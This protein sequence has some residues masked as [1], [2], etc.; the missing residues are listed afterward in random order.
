MLRP[1]LFASCS[2]TNPRTICSSGPRDNRDRGNASSTHS[3]AG[4]WQVEATVVLEGEFELEFV[5]ESEIVRVGRALAIV[6][7]TETFG[8]LSLRE[9]VAVMVDRLQAENL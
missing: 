4:E 3:I 8:P 6:F 9:V 5:V 7:T 2:Q 1:S